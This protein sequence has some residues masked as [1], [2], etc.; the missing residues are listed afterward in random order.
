MRAASW[1]KAIV[2][3][4][5]VALAPSASAQARSAPCPD[6][7]LL[8]EDHV[9]LMCT[10]GGF[11]TRAAASIEG[12]SSSLPHSAFAPGGRPTWA[13]GGFWAPDLEHVGDQYLLYFSARRSDNRHCIGVAVSDSP[14]GGFVDTGAPLVDDE[15]DGAID[16]ALL[17]LSGQLY[18]LYK[19]DGNSV[20][21]PTVI[22]GRPLS[23]DGLHLAGRRVQ[24]LR[25]T[26][27]VEAPAP[28]PLANATYLLYSTGLFSTP[29]YA[30]REAVMTGDS[31]GSFR[32]VSRTPVLH[33][34]GKW[35]GTGGGSVF[36][37]SGRLMLAYAAFARGLR[38][39]RRLLF[40]RELAM[41]NTVL[42]PVG[43]AQQVRLLP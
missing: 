11:P 30:E 26:G 37:D 34:S 35:V 18:L 7:T 31:L 22:F 25:S 24:L 9:T 43:E 2:A 33:S 40:I 3:A 19:R 14:D 4:G 17:S 27:I 13:R 10:G 39:P 16:P 42:R 41:E 32:R 8:V 23:A 6:P 38:P 15:P 21:A 1:G 20:G 5:A 29:G 36:S 12:L 28:V